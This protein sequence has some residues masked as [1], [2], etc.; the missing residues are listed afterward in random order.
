M[1]VALDTKNRRNTSKTLTLRSPTEAGAKSRRT[2]HDAS[3]SSIDAL[4]ASFSALPSMSTLVNEV[5]RSM[6]AAIA[7]ISSTSKPFLCKSMSI[8]RVL[9]ISDT[10]SSIVIP[11]LSRSRLRIGHADK[12]VNSV[13]NPVRSSLRPC[14]ERELA[15]CC[16]MN[17]CSASASPLFASHSMRSLSS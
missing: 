3:I 1:F 9:S 12:A 13:A 15:P 16:A 8:R 6:A 14:N 10:A 17:C 7:A 4:Q 11:V 2:K 5:L